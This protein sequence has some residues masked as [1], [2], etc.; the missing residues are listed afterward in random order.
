M[1]TFEVTWLSSVIRFVKYKFNVQL[2]NSRSYWSSKTI[3]LVQNERL[4]LT[5]RIFRLIVLF[6]SVHAAFTDL[7]NFIHFM[8]DHTI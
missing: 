2:R 3:R 7:Q 1:R 8:L 6:H 4:M 5:A